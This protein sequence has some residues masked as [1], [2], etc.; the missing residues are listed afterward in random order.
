M[1]CAVEVRPMQRSSTEGFCDKGSAGFWGSCGLR[2]KALT[3]STIGCLQIF[4]EHPGLAYHGHEVRVCHPARKNVHVDMSSNAGSGS[5]SQVHSQVQ[6]VGTVKP[7]Q[8][9]FEALGEFHH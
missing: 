9:S 6:P 7:P 4:G 2:R 5:F 8:N 1:P 3:K